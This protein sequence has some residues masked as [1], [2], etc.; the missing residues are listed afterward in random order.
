MGLAGLHSV[1]FGP[2]LSASW[3]S[4]GRLWAALGRLLGS[5]G[6]FLAPSWALLGRSW[7]SLGWSE[8]TFGRIL[9]P[10]GTPGLDFA[11]FGDVPSWVL[12]GFGGIFC[13]VLC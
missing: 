13:H 12:E 7:T 5:L 9:P 2:L 3:V 4:L 11:R 1:G 8:K 6:R 10:R